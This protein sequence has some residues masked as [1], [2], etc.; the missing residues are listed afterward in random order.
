MNNFIILSSLLIFIKLIKSVPIQFKTIGQ[1]PNVI[2]LNNY[3]FIVYSSNNFSVYD[4]TNY[5]YFYNENIIIEKIITLQNEKIML[6]GKNKNFL[7]YTIYDFSTIYNI[8]NGQNVNIN[9]GNNLTKEYYVININN[10]LDNFDQFNLKYFE[11][12]QILVYIK[13]NDLN[14][15]YKIFLY[16]YTNNNSVINIQKNIIGTESFNNS[17]IECEKYLSNYI[18]CAYQMY[19]NKKYKIQYLLLNNQ[20][21]NI[22]L[23]VPSEEEQTHFKLHKSIEDNYYVLCY[24][25]MDLGYKQC[26]YLRL[27]YY[28]TSYKIQ[29]KNKQ[30]LI[31]DKYLFPFINI[32]NIENTLFISILDMGDNIIHNYLY[33]YDFNLQYHT[34][35]FSYNS[36]E[37]Y[38]S[39]YF[40]NYIYFYIYDKSLEL[41]GRYYV[42]LRYYEIKP[43]DNLIY[44]INLKKLSNFNFNTN[45]RFNTTMFFYNVH[46]K[47][48]ISISNFMIDIKYA[49]DYSDNFFLNYTNTENYFY[50][51]LLDN[52]GIYSYMC[53]ITFIKCYE[54]CNECIKP[55]SEENHFC[56]SCLEPYK[57]FIMSDS[58]TNYYNC[59]LENE[60]NFYY[61]NST[62]LHFKPCINNCMKCNN[63]VQCL[64]CD[65]NYY[66]KDDDNNSSCNLV[67]IEGYFLNLET[68]LLSKCNS[69][70][71]F[72]N[73]CFGAGNN[74][75]HNCK[76]C[77][78]GYKIYKFDNN[79]CKIDKSLCNNYYILKSDSNE[80]ECLNN[81]NGYYSIDN[82][83]YNKLCVE[84]CNNF[85]DVDKYGIDSILHYYY[86]IDN[87]SRTI[88][89]PKSKCD[90]FEYYNE[91]I[92]CSSYNNK[93][94]IS[95]ESSSTHFHSDSSSSKNKNNSN[96]SNNKDNKS[97]SSNSHKEIGQ[98]DSDSANNIDINKDN[99]HIFK[100]FDRNIYFNKYVIY[101]NISKIK[102]ISIYLSTLKNEKKIYNDIELI[103]LIKEIDFSVMIYKYNVNN[104]FNNYFSNYNLTFI[105]FSNLFNNF[106]RLK[107][108]SS[109]SSILIFQID[110]L[111]NN[112][113]TNQTEYI[114]F[115]FNET[116]YNLKKINLLNYSNINITYYYSI[117]NINKIQEIIL[118]GYEDEINFFDINHPFFNDIC[119]TY[120]NE[121]GRDVTIMDRR[122]YYFLN[123]T[124]CENNCSL[125]KIYYEKM[126]SVCNCKLKQS[127]SNII[128][129][130]YEIFINEK[131]IPNIK[132][133]SCGN[134]ILKINNLKK[135]K[136]FTFSI[137]ILLFQFLILIWCCCVG[138]TFLETYID[139]QLKFENFSQDKNEIFMKK[140]LKKRND[141]IISNKIKKNQNFKLSLINEK[142]DKS[143]ILNE[144]INLLNSKRNINNSTSF[145]FQNNNPSNP[146]KKQFISTNDDNIKNN[147]SSIV[148]NDNINVNNEHVY[149]ENINDKKNLE[150]EINNSTIGIEEAYISQVK[151]NNFMK[152]LKQEDILTNN[153]IK[154][155]KRNKYNFCNIKNSILETTQDLKLFNKRSNS[156]ENDIQ[157]LNFS[158]I[159][160]INE[161]YYNLNSANKNFFKKYNS[162]Y[163]PNYRNKLK[164]K[165]LALYEEESSYLNKNNKNMYL[166]N[167]KSN[168]LFLNPEEIEYLKKMQKNNKFIFKLFRYFKKREILLLVLT[169]ET[170]YYPSYA[171]WSL[172]LCILTLIFSLHCLLFTNNYIHKRF[173][174]EY[175]LNFGYFF[176]NELGKCVLV[177]L[178]SV[179]LKMLLIKLLIFKLFNFKD[180][181]H[182]KN[183]KQNLSKL[184]SKL[185]LFF[186]V[187]ICISF[188]CIYINICY[189][190]IF[191]NNTSSLFYG[192][193]FSY[194]F[195]FI[196]CLII[197]I[198]ITLLC[199]IEECFDLEIIKY[200]RHI[201]KI[202]Y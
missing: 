90:N 54:T 99:V 80:I 131:T 61:F 134:E 93:T 127:F 91:K 14:C 64:I 184:G 153:Y 5:Y 167:N 75:N 81:C 52:N 135:N 59:Y 190:G 97:T 98:D 161:N 58:S 177:G 15:N 28:K 63:D 84:D 70:Q 67:N 195:S 126:I 72:C 11:E 147:N 193:I 88:C 151:F 104:N 8:I 168:N 86:Y 164:R 113:Y 62:A 197:C 186:F 156:F 169:N 122:N 105:N 71:Y 129:N 137:F 39:I 160:E 21:E 183:K 108:D 128:E 34:F 141:I 158:L 102:E 7:Y 170:E 191:K 198:I 145:M 47:Y 138:K 19:L 172:F 68:N 1:F 48:N 181:I 119:F 22:T 200:I 82:S 50:Y 46:K 187:I 87:N 175:N 2:E 125:E 6:I 106:R 32:K 77:I 55:G 56:L 73:T 130:N 176:T 162:V 92:Y 85:I 142:L 44:N 159:S 116:N 57:P 40:S 107:S 112:E 132:V 89:V 180:N 9:E 45:N 155:S 78:G 94:D 110:A 23:E 24:R 26:N 148:T 143:N 65:K 123:K 36:I 149:S 31:V 133:L 115:Y 202:V 163:L 165:H 152:N 111:R 38:D 49:Y 182:K 124:L 83:K 35:S 188:L 179:I 16:N 173:I 3:L 10:E 17:N 74:T 201:I 192:L 76:T 199:K 42:D 69:N 166:F 53:K 30:N 60:I 194:L 150:N 154:K 29:I 79:N 121:K 120:T 185:I 103:T 178:I 174:Y 37:Y 146:P 100:L 144:N 189:G 51:Y 114:F 171:F 109:E 140:K 20:F 157:N 33:S 95:S 66:L 4:G 25:N 196:F 139:K 18:F 96:S 101:K 118:K 27:F 12:N 117:R 13:V 43:C 41:V 136:I